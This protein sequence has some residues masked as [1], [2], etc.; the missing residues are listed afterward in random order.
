MTITQRLAGR[1]RAYRPDD[2]AVVMRDLLPVIAESYPRA[3]SWLEQ[4]LEDV[5]AGSASCDLARDR[6]GLRAIAIQ[7]PK[8]RGAVKLSTIWVAERARGRHLG[9]QLADR[10]RRIW[11]AADVERAWVTVGEGAESSVSRLLLPRGFIVTQVEA[12]RYAE[13]GR[14][15]VLY[16]TPE[17]D[18]YIAGARPGLCGPNTR[19]VPALA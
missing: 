15:T 4:R 10:A 12:D 5:A 17:R 7:T 19:M 9:A 8:G 3:R 6:H 18:P 11:I 16:W 14:E 1:V 13:G 2:Y